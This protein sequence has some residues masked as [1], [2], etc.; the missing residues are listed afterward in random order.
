MQF[1]RVVPLSP[2]GRE[3]EFDACGVV[4][5]AVPSD[6]TPPP[7]R[8]H[9]SVDQ[10]TR[11]ATV[12]IAAVGLD[13]VELKAAEPGL[14]TAAARSGR[15]GPAVPSA[16]R[17]RRRQRS[18]LRARDRARTARRSRATARD[19]VFMAEV[20]D[21]VAL[22]SFIRYSYWAEVRMPPERRLARA[23]SRSRRPAVW[24]R[25]FRRRSPTCRARSARCRRRHPRSTCRH[26]PC[27]RSRAQ[28]RPRSSMPARVR[29]QPH[30]AVDACRLAQG[31]RALSAAD[32]GTMGRHSRSRPRAPTSR[33]TAR[34]SR[35][36]ATRRRTTRSVRGR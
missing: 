32:L 4:P 31:R 34:R 18:R 13:L 29:A 15:R 20:A 5:V 3:A 36:K 10:A 23:S 24:H 16:A 27:R 11:I 17:V 30:R 28:R 21:P 1:L 8:V 6:R 26:C 9:V 22:E 33:S 19:I 25:S 2:Q 12:T 35:G 7:P 14:F